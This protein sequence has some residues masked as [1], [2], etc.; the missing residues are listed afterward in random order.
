ML[1]FAVFHSSYNFLRDSNAN[2]IRGLI[3][4]G[5]SFICWLMTAIMFIPVIRT[6]TNVYRCVDVPVLGAVL[7][8]DNTIQCWNASHLMYTIPAAVGLLLFIFISIRLIRVLND[9]SRVA[10]FFWVNWRFDEPDVTKVHIASKRSSAYTITQSL[11]AVVLLA[12]SI[13]GQDQTPLAVS[14]TFLG[15]TS[16]LIVTGFIW[17]P[18]WRYDSIAALLIVFDVGWKYLI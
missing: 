4:R 12:L 1:T 8:A 3:W 7:Q 2:T 5:T 6:F 15:I 11:A 13:F 14:A 18:Y 16:F 17:L 9:L 10:V